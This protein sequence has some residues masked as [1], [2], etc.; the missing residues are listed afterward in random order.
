MKK[1]AF[2]GS[3]CLILATSMYSCK[4]D[5]VT[6]E[7]NTAPTSTINTAAL[8]AGTAKTDAAIVDDTRTLQTQLNA[9]NVTL[10][11]GKT[12]NITNLKVSHALNLNGATLNCTTTSYGFAITMNGYGASVTNGTIKGKWSSY[13]R[14]NASG[15]SGMYILA[16]HC[17]VSHVNISS[18]SGYGIVVS[19]VNSSSV[20]YCNISNTGY[21]GYF[22]DAESKSTS[23]GK[24]S[25]NVVDRS[26]VPAST[27]QQMAIGIRGSLTNP[28]VTTS[29]WTIT[30]N[31][32]KM[33]SMPYDWSAET[34]EIRYCNNAYIANN[35]TT[36]GSIGLSLVFCTGD[37]LQNNTT[38]GAKLEGIE[39]ADCNN[40]KTWNN[41]VPSSHGAGILLDGN[42]GCNGVQLNGDKISGT[43]QECIH[44]FKKTRNL[45][46]TS[47]TLTSATKG[48]YGI[49][50]QNS[51]GVK[52]QSN[53]I[54]GNGLANAAVVVDNCPGNI[55]LTGGSVANFKSCVV[56]IYNSTYG[57]KTDN[58]YM[59]GVAVSGTPKKLNSVLMNGGSLGS[60]VKL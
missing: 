17:S 22:Y 40:C 33:P 4:K 32:L 15:Y 31:V 5:S 35:V 8:N 6:P 11:A 23:G 16:S 53:K 54:N 25:N 9:G 41:V 47:C 26:M 36:G 10:T 59:S 38:S 30:N 37:V 57:L 56:S 55:T 18:F 43:V 27:I 44:A 24:F 52:I 58:V 45:T 19:A 46:V 50:L 48:T 60:N 34:A 21:I 7:A 49:N 20:T 39:F 28:R 29:N 42:N 2:W 13:S 14:G 3:V 1:T 12:Y 51:N